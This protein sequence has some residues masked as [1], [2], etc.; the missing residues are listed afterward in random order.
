MTINSFRE[1]A[2]PSRTARIKV[3]ALVVVLGFFVLVSYTFLHEA[4]H[5]L[6]G[7]AFGQTLTEFNLNFWDLSAHVSMQGDLTAAQRALQSVAGV[8]LPLVV[9]ALFV[10]LAPRRANLSLELLKLV[11][12]MAVV[13]TLLAWIIIPL[14]DLFGRAPAGDDVTHFLRASQMP[15]L[16]LTAVALS[17]Y[18][19]GWALY[20]ART[21]G[22]RQV[23]VRVREADTAE[24]MAG[25][26]PLLGVLVA[27]MALG[28]AVVLLLNSAAPNVSYSSAPPADFQPAATID[29]STRAYEAETLA[30]ITLGETG[31]LGV[32]FLVQNIDTEYFDLSLSGPDGYRAVVLHGED[33]RTDSL[34][35]SSLQEFNLRAGEYQLVLTARQNPG[36]LTVSWGVH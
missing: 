8:G 36:H 18:A 24:I 22:L 1:T 26:R 19:L 25:T 34:G 7:L 13:N 27:L 23:I 14:L 35:A 15:P 9:W 2:V 6:V 4:G 20:Q 5:A 33:F 28:L 12:A 10:S 17:L 31:T 3:V 21:E 32:H 30:R 16:L 29:L 11:S